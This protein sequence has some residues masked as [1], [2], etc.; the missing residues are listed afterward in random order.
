[1]FPGEYLLVWK[2]ELGI[3]T[4]NCFHP[5]VLFFYVKLPFL[6]LQNPF[7]ASSSEEYFLTPGH[8][9]SPPPLVQVLELRGA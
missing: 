8:L 4:Q 1:V 5:C 2:M 7:L 3:G 6:F 9:S